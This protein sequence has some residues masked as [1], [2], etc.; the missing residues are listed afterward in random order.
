MDPT[1]R[2]DAAARARLLAA[3]GV[4]YL[5]WSSTYLAVRH[6]VAALPPMLVGGARF[7]LAGAML[8]AVQRLRGEA[9]R[10]QDWGPAAASG[11]L[12]FTVSNGFVCLAETRVSSGVAAVACAA[13]PLVVAALGAVTGERPSARELL[14]LA[15]GFAGV[16]ALGFGA[17]VSSAGARG[18]LLLVAPVAWALGTVIARRARPSSAVSFAAQQMVCGG[19]AM[20]VVG[21]ALGERMP[22][23]AP[24]AAWVAWAYLVLIGSVVTFPAYGYLVRHARPAVATSYAYVN[25]AIAVLL[26]VALGGEA[27]TRST[28]GALAL[29]VAAVGLLAM[30]PSPR[31]VAAA[32]R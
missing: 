20:L 22:A 9:P 12:L 32:A 17:D 30:R 26:G 29:V 23:T 8:F 7:V 13:T 16:A 4:V 14:S 21:A 3:L 18:A 1:H 11:V 15:L 25:P 6:V 31:P 2:P 24:T 19:A 10:R 28:A 5:V 27:L